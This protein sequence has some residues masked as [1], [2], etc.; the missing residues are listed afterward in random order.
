MKYLPTQNSNPFIAQY[1][2]TKF[3]IS[4]FFSV[5]F[6]SIVII[7]YFFIKKSWIRQTRFHNNLSYFTS[8]R[9]LHPLYN[10][11]IIYVL[12]FYHYTSVFI[13]TLIFESKKKLK[14]QMTKIQ[15]TMVLEYFYIFT[16]SLNILK[17]ILVIPSFLI[18][19]IVKSPKLNMKIC[20]L[21]NELSFIFFIISRCDSLR[22]ACT[23]YT[24]S[25]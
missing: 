20:I 21:N 19:I 2:S 1:I 8:S 5:N 14:I 3:L 22:L 25:F 7:V 9:W 13:Y 18:I 23:M 4:L 24:R 6:L 12:T 17:Q 11:Y 15:R 16:F 10:V